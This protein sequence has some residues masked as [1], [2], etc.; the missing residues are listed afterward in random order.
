MP[1]YLVGAPDLLEKI[2]WI[3][4]LHLVGIPSSPGKD[5]CPSECGT[6]VYT[7][8]NRLGVNAL[9]LTLDFPERL[10]PHSLSALSG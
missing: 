1:S 4:R 5:A 2:F 8:K 7:Q 10:V 3:D 6:W 9:S